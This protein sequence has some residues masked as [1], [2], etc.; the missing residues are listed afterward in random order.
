MQ[1]LKA[2]VDADLARVLNE[3]FRTLVFFGEN[4]SFFINSDSFRAINGFYKIKL[5]NFVRYD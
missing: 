5:K 2:S 3:K 4:Q 1:G